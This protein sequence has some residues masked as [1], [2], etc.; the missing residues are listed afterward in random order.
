M[1]INAI[2]KQ[3]KEVSYRIQE[4][5]KSFQSYLIKL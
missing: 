5:E 3:E 4:I 1:D 2:E